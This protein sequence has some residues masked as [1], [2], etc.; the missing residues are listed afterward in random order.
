MPEP[1]RSL[2]SLSD[3]TSR[4]SKSGG[5]LETSLKVGYN[6]LHEKFG[7]GKVIRLEGAGSEKKAVIF[8]PQE[9]SKTLLLKFAKL[10]ILD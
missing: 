10:E 4:P 2:R 3:V 5:E 9:G 7:K 8:F 6:V 1:T